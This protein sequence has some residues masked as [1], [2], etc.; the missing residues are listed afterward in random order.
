MHHLDDPKE[1][2]NLSSIAGIK[3]QY[4]NELL[5]DRLIAVYGKYPNIEKITHSLTNAIS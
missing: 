4:V 5:L 2:R 3:T 1:Q